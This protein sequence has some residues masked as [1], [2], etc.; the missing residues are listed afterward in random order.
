M[1]RGERDNDNCI[2]SRYQP[3]KL[4]SNRSSECE[5]LK[6]D[7]NEMGQVIANNGSTTKDRTCR[8]DYNKGFDF[9]IKPKEVCYCIPSEE[10]CS[11][12]KKNCLPGQILTQ[13]IY[14]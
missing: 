9:I 3:F 1:I 12:Y 2:D 11:C 7:C 5:F 8:C 6:N 13:G 4:W 14:L 10:D